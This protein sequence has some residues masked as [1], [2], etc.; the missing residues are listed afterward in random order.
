VMR[1]EEWEYACTR[2][3]A[4]RFPWGDKL[5][6]TRVNTGELG[7]MRSTPVGTFESGRR[8]D[9]AFDLIGNVGEWTETVRS[10]PAIRTWEVETLRGVRYEWPLLERPLAPLSLPPD[11]GGFDLTRPYE[12]QGAM[13]AGLYLWVP[14]W[15]PLPA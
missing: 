9:A 5:D 4:N 7:L 2:G 3:G 10:M 12:R 15:M 6:A 14:L 8:G 11:M 1:A 13:P